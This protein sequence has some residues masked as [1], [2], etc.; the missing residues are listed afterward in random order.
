LADS[1]KANFAACINIGTPTSLPN[2]N[3][4]F[5]KFFYFV[6]FFLQHIL[7]V[8]ENLVSNIHNVNNFFED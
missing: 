3:I 5:E 2:C 1:K 8:N 4:V 7:M 6:F